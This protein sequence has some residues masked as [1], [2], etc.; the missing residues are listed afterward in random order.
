[1]ARYTIL[2]WIPRRARKMARSIEELKSRYNSASHGQSLRGGPGRGGPGPRAKGKPQNVRK[3]IGRLLS[4]VG[5]YKIF[6]FVVLFF[7]LLNTV[8]SLIGGYMTRP[9]INR[10]SE[11]V[12][13][14]KRRQK[15]IAP[16]CA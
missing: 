3:T 8:T 2:R 1:M 7:M 11:Y 16:W 14:W 9:I 15:T 6:L 13:P 12:T 4:Y 5:K 10:L